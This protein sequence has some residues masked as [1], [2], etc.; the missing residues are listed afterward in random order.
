MSHDSNPGSGTELNISFRL[1]EMKNLLKGPD[2][3]GVSILALQ[4][5]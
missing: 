1:L 4:M 2:K 5:F 3:S